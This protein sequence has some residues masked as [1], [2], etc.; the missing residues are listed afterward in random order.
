[1]NDNKEDKDKDAKWFGIF[2]KFP[3]AGFN[4]PC[5]INMFKELKE[6]VDDIPCPCGNPNHWLLKI[7]DTNG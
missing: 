2:L 7:E 1:M 6:R 4:P 5:G 3:S